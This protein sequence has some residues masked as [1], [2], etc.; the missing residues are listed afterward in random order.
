MI[1]SEEEL[2]K[3]LLPGRIRGSTHVKYLRVFKRMLG[4]TVRQGQAFW[5]SLFLFLVSTLSVMYIPKVA[6]DLIDSLQEERTD[7]VW[8]LVCLILVMVV[9]TGFKTYLVNTITKRAQILIYQDLMRHTYGLEPGRLALLKDNE[10]A[11]EILYMDQSEALTGSTLYTN[12][13]T[14]AEFLIRCGVLCYI[15]W[16][17]A[18]TIIW[19]LPVLLV[20]ALVYVSL[21]RSRIQR[22]SDA[23]AKVEAYVFQAAPSARFK[24]NCAAVMAGL[25]RETEKSF[26]RVNDGSLLAALFVSGYYLFSYG[27]IVVTLLEGGRMLRKGSI[28]YGQFT[29]FI[30]YAVTLVSG[31]ASFSDQAKVFLKALN[32]YD[33]VWTF[34]ALQEGTLQGI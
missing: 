1:H 25:E 4:Y 23:Q 9:S 21:F 33:R 7:S 17:L 24:Q 28:T 22:A 6:G 19:I 15:S 3:R 2:S 26:M 32:N 14:M 16:P 12:F 29:S 18:A 10:L 13:Q 5:A 34:Y 8:L 27:L 31:L 30:V 11:I 20:Y